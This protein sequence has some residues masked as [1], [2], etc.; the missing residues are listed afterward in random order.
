MSNGDVTQPLYG[1]A[2]AEGW[3]HYERLVLAHLGRQDTIMGALVAQVNKI[4]ETNV[5]QN[6]LLDRIENVHLKRVEETL[7]AHLAMDRDIRKQMAEFKTGNE[8]RLTRIEA[9][10]VRNSG[11]AG[12]LMAAVVYVVM[13]FVGKLWRI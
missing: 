2:P 7:N 5:V 8:N 3:E 13:F 4:E 10:A 12:A 6:V 1:R 11:L 9:G